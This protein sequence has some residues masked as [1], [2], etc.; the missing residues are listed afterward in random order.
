MPYLI[1]RHPSIVILFSAMLFLLAAVA[2]GSS[3][4]PVI[5]EKEV[6]REVVKE[7]PI[8]KEVI[9]EVPKEVIIEKEVIKEVIKEV[10][11]FATPLPVAP[12]AVARAGGPSGTLTVSLE[13]LGAQVT[14][15]ILQSRDRKSVV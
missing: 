15:P 3:A 11:V 7:V 14:D 5:V 6:V 2:C 8:F 4:E 10:L 12:A 9:K 13:N 1:P